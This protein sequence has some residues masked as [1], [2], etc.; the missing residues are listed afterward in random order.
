[1][2][3]GLPDDEE[4]SHLSPPAKPR[5]Q[6]GPAVGRCLPSSSLGRPACTGSSVLLTLDIQGMSL[7]TLYFPN[8]A[9]RG[10]QELKGN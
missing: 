9:L 4:Q 5:R 7:T 1:V 10:C 2:A 8:P 3:L 6:L